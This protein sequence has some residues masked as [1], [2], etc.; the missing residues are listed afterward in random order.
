MR[1]S[2]M[3]SRPRLRRGRHR[4]V[5]RRHGR[6]TAHGS[7]SAH[8]ADALRHP[9]LLQVAK[10]VTQA[11][12]DM[13]NKVHCLWCPGASTHL[14]PR[15]SRVNAFLALAPPT[16]ATPLPVVPLGCS[17]RPASDPPSAPARRLGTQPPASSSLPGGSAA[18]GAAWTPPR[19]RCATK[20]PSVW[21]RQ[22]P[23]R[24]AVAGCRPATAAA[25]GGPG[26]LCP[27][28]AHCHA[29]TMPCWG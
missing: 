28:P 1:L 6:P 5:H 24:C 9:R 19:S 16:S 7:S 13:S 3:P 21:R 2:L 10:D 26:D 27:M 25:R 17:C 15:A 20:R 23:T 29:C 8:M 14:P 12:K 11:A 4:Y 18:G 22:T